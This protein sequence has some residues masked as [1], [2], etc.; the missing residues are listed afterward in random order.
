MH[1][2]FCAVTVRQCVHMSAPRHTVKRHGSLRS[3]R[4]VAHQGERDALQKKR[5]FDKWLQVE[6]P[7]ELAKRVLTWRQSLDKTAVKKLEQDPSH[8]RHTGVTRSRYGTVPYRSVV[9]PLRTSAL[10]HC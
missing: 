10:P 5:D 9:S 1:G 6:Y 4:S 7:V 8:G 3:H 2:E